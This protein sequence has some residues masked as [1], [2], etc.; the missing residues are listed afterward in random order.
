MHTYWGQFLDHD[1]TWSPELE[2][3]L[4][5]IPIPVQN[6]V[7]FNP[8]G[9]TNLTM[10]FKRSIFDTT[11]GHDACKFQFPGRDLLIPFFFFF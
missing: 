3:D 2:N 11:T 8:L 1:I 4:L 9:T 10:K 6:D 7:F 5:Y